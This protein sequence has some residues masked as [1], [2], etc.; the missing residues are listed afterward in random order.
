MSASVPKITKE[1]VKTITD[2]KFLRF[3]TFNIRKES[4]ILM[5]P[6]EMPKSWWQPWMRKNSKK[7]FRMPLAAL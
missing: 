6:E 4:I 5:H 1:C 2:N 7:C 3:M